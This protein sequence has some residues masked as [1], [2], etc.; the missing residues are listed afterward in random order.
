MNSLEDQPLPNFEWAGDA[1]W[2][3]DSKSIAVPT[4]TGLMKMQAPNGAL[5]LVTTDTNLHTFRGGSWNDQGTI[6]F[7]AIDSLPGRIG[8][9]GVPAAGGKAIPVEIPG[10]KDGR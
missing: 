2:A 3:P 10:L 1:F 4:V 8:L 6:L 7:A 9:Y 5:E